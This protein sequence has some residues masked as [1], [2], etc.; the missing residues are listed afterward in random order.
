M[1]LLE[2]SVRRKKCQRYRK[3]S[4]VALLGDGGSRVAA[5]LY[6]GSSARGYREILYCASQVAGVDEAFE[7]MMRHRL[8]HSAE[9]A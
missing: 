7:G 3:T 8:K 5:L 9:K 2:A 4:K 6:A 1:A